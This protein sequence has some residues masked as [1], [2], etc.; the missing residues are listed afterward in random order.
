MDSAGK[1]TTCP[2]EEGPAKGA[3]MAQVARD[4]VV[5]LLASVGCRKGAHWAVVGGGEVASL[6]L[7]GLGAA[8]P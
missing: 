1:A 6:A 4:K 7:W 8:V 3:G 2:T 5:T